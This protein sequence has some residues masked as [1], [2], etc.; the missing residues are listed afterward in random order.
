MNW[1][2][3]EKKGAEP[4]QDP[5]TGFRL[6][7]QMPDPNRELDD[8]WIAV[9]NLADTSIDAFEERVS[10]VF[11]DRSLLIPVEYD[12]EER[13]EVQKDQAVVLFARVP[14]LLALNMFQNEFGVTGI[15]LGT[16]VPRDELSF[17]LSETK[18]LEIVKVP[19]KSVV[20]AVIDDGMA[21]GHN[22]FR[23]GMTSSRVH[24]A[25]V[26]HSMGG[27]HP[28][29]RGRCIEKPEI[30]AALVTH[31]HN[32]LLDEASFYH[33]LDIINHGDDVFSPAALRR[34]HGTH[35]MSMAAGYDMGDAKGK[36]RP[37]LCA[38]LPP[39]VTQDTTGQDLRPSLALAFRV[40]VRHA[41]RF[42]L[43]D[44]SYAPVV[45]NFSYG[46]FAGPHDGTGAITQL[47]EREMRRFPKQEKRI[48]LPAG[49]GNL[50]RTHARVTFD[51]SQPDEVTLRMMVLPDDRTASFVEMWMPW[52]ATNTPPPNHVRV[53]VTSPDGQTSAPVDV[54]SP[55]PTVLPDDNGNPIAELVYAFHSLP[56]QRG[57]ITLSL[58]PTA[59]LNGSAPLAPSGQWEIHLERV[60]LKAD[61]AVEVWIRR[62]DTLPGFPPHGRQSY[63]SNACYQRFDA[64]GRPLAVDPPGSDCPVRRA[65][66]LNG[67]ADGVSPIVLGA[68]VDQ[69]GEMSD[70]SAAGPITPTRGNPVAN[71]EGP[72]ASVRADDS[73]VRLGTIGAGSASGSMLRQ[74]GTSTSTPLA[75]RYLADGLAGGA[76]GDRAWLS[77]QAAASDP[78]IP[79]PTPIA[80]RTGGGRLDVTF[81]FEPHD[82]SV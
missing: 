7:R 14:V 77:A 36:R 43:P 78:S 68:F 66:T 57:A 35:V 32:G 51:K 45:F 42:R 55:G 19:E 5:V 70:Y 27:G 2:Y 40:L 4:V 44:G 67:F 52:S 6:S 81:R 80:T 29:T 60:D 38:M 56:T 74:G 76:A 28:H 31:T 25:Y 17:E 30:D 34:S 41:R 48:L 46:N 71:R 24:M 39:L 13:G 26:M 37:I 64:I 22:L 73:L 10:G 23:D 69:N 16:A 12:A 15:L 61:E 79:G 65:G 3:D 21:I 11:K 59:S 8:W 72:D 62:D 58:N 1:E 54:T 49:N 82:P 63:F 33:E 18:P 53:R 9:V 50:S 20:M 47:I 75:A